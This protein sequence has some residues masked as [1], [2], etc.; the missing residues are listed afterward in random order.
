MNNF[1]DIA[2]CAVVVLAFA[3]AG[4]KPDRK[5]PFGYGR[6]EYIAGFVVSVV[7]TL[8][9][10]LFA[11]SALS[12]LSLP[13]PVWFNWLYFGIVAATAA[14]KLLMGFA[15]RK[16]NRA[17][18]SGAVRALMFDSFLDCGITTMALISFLLMRYSGSR[19]DAVFG[20]VISGIVIAG[21]IRLIFSSGRELLGRGADAETASRV[22]EI[23]E[24]HEGVTAGELELH[25]YGYAFTRGMLEL[26]HEKGAAAALSEGGPIASEIKKKLNIDIKII[27]K[28]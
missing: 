2:S 17:L 20:L 7:V 14:V 13:I 28:L 1:A 9:G 12:R 11:Y 16:L 8:V 27:P 22:K 10:A 4:K 23:A 25:R 24:A 3:L 5:H 19:L 18:K 21:G 6:T 26:R 15:Y